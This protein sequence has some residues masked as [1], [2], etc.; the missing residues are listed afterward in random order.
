MGVLPAGCTQICYLI[1][2]FNL[3][4]FDSY[5]HILLKNSIKSLF[6]LQETRG[7]RSAQKLGYVDLNLSQFAGQGEVA[8]NYLLQA[9]EES[10]RLDN[11]TLRVQITMTLTEGYPVFKV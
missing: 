8:K 2:H 1:I 5:H 9:Y 11:S 4:S 7:G 10:H 3:Y 6:C